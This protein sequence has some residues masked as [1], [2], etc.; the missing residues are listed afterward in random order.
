MND[1]HLPADGQVC[2]NCAQPG[3]VWCQ[4]VEIPD[5]LTSMPAEFV[6]PLAHVML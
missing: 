1:D 4:E 3:H 6:E 2:D 5:A